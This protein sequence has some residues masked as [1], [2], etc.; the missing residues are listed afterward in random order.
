MTAK[1][2]KK[3][4]KDIPDDTLIT[5]VGED[6]DGNGLEEYAMGQYMKKKPNKSI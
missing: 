2:L 1:D 3:V 4:L 5:I 6:G